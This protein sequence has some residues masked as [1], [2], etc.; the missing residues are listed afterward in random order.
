MDDG[1][2]PEWDLGPLKKYQP[3][4]LKDEACR[5]DRNR[6]L[7]ELLGHCVHNLS[8]DLLNCV[9]CCAYFGEIFDNKHAVPDYT[10]DPRLVLREMRAREDWNEFCAEHLVD[11]EG[12]DTF[13]LLIDLFMDETGK[14][15]D[16]A[17]KWLKERS[18]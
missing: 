4:D 18:A 16:I 5:V 6:E 10:A 3:D 17:I 1:M 7:H 12:W 8:P 11:Y 2:N 13:Y 14:L 9:I 15:V